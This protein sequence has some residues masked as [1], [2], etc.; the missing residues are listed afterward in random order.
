MDFSGKT[1]VVTGAASGIGRATARE[2]GRRGADVALLDI[3]GDGANR[4]AA[5]LEILGCN[6]FTYEFDLQHREQLGGAFDAVYERFGRIDALANVAGI[7]PRAHVQD[8]TVEYWELVISV[9]LRAAFFCCQDALRVM[10]AQGSGSIVNVASGAAFR[11]IAGLSVYAAAKSGLVGMSR[12]LAL[13]YA[14][15]GIRVNVVAPG[16]TSSDVQYEDGST[17]DGAADWAAAEKLVPGRYMAPDESANAIV[18]LCSD[19]ATGVNGAIVHVNG[20][21]Y[22]P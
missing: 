11:P 22:M 15:K 20:G 13:E 10:E 1:A 19:D 9:N 3:D 17:A 8:V 12:V 6:A 21:N 7:Y 2:F 5:E 18:W 4:V 14:R 16:H